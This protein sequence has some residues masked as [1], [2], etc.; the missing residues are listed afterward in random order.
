[1]GPQNPLFQLGMLMVSPVQT[2]TP[3]GGF[4]EKECGRA[5]SKSQNPPEAHLDQ[6]MVQW[7]LRRHVIAIAAAASGVCATNALVRRAA[8]E[9]TTTVTPSS[10]SILV[11]ADPTGELAPTTATLS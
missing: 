2:V 6:D 1:M 9:S 4:V 8:F 3:A 10:D 7:W 5:M 11:N